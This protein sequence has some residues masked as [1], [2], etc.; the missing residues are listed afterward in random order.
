MEKERRGICPSKA[1]TW[2][3]IHSRGGKKATL[4]QKELQGQRRFVRQSSKTDL[5]RAD[6]S[7][8]INVEL[9]AA[10][11]HLPP[12]SKSSTRLMDAAV[13]TLS[14]LLQNSTPGTRSK[15]F[16]IRPWWLLARGSVQRPTGIHASTWACT[17]CMRFSVSC[18][19]LARLMSLHRFPA[20]PLRSCVSNA[21]LLLLCSTRQVPTTMCTV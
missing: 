14:R 19:D 11:Q 16:L 2:V 10:S 8:I 1:F 4:M 21:R 17:L 3:E 20:A 6:G 13:T 5:A 15:P 7:N 12:N 9:S 18:P